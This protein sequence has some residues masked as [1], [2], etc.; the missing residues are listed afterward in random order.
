MISIFAALYRFSYRISVHT[1]A[2]LVPLLL[3]L[4]MSL[5]VW[6]ILQCNK[7][8]VRDRFIKANHGDIDVDLEEQNEEWFN[9]AAAKLATQNDLT[10]KTPKNG[11]E[12]G[13]GSKPPFRGF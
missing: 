3:I 5:S 1:A 4:T 7:T 13:R 9:E 10:R 11:L 12:G 6:L 8:R 2:W